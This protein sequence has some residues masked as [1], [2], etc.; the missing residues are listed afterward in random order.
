MSQMDHFKHS[1]V[2]LYMELGD[3]PS[4]VTNLLQRFLKDD[5][6]IVGWG[7]G[8]KGELGTTYRCNLITPLIIG[9]RDKAVRIGCASTTSVW[10]GARGTVLTMG[11]GRWGELGV[12]N[13]KTCPLVTAT[14]NGLPIAIVQ[15][16]LPTFARED[17][18]IDV[19]G[20]FAY[21]AALSVKGELFLWGANN[22]AQ[23]SPIM[24]NKCCPTAQRRS[25]LSEKIIQVACSNFTVLAL[26]ASG[27][28]Y[29]WGHTFLLGD[30][31]EVLE[32]APEDSVFTL[33]FGLVDRTVVSEPVKVKALE[34][35]SIKLLRMGPWHAVAVSKDGQ[36]Y[37]WGLGRNGSLGHGTESDIRTPTKVTTLDSV[38]T[39]AACGSFHTCFVS[40]EGSVFACGDNQGG[41]CGVFGEM[42]LTTCYP[43]YVPSYH[44]VI[45]ATCGRHHTLLLLETG[46]VIAYGTGLGL[47]IGTGYSMRMVRGV[48]ILDNYT[49]L[50]LSGGSC[51]NFSLAIPKTLS[52]VVLGI[53]HGDVS[54]ALRVIDLKD[55]LLTAGLGQ[56]FSIL[57][58]RRGSCYSMGLGGWGQ[59]GVDVRGVKDFTSD[60]V[61]VVRNAMRLSYFFRTTITQVSAGICFAAAINEGQ[62]VFTWGSNTYGQC[63]LGVN[64]KEYRIISEPREITWLADKLI[65]QVAC[66]CFFGMA[67]SITG[68]VYT[69]GAIECCGNGLQP[70][71]TDVPA[72]LIMNSLGNESHASVL[73]PV[74][75]SGLSSIVSVAAGAWHAVALNAIGEVFV[76]GIGSRGRLGLGNVEDR[77]VPGK[78]AIRAPFTHVGCGPFSTFAITDDGRLYV[79]GANERNQLSAEGNCVTVPTHV[80]DEVKEAVM[81]RH[82]TLVLTRDGEF[83][84]SG[85]MEDENGRYVSPSFYDTDA[86]PPL[87]SKDMEEP[88]SRAIRI[89]GGV[90]HAMVLFE[91][92][93]I[94]SDTITGLYY[95]LREQPKH[96]ITNLF[97]H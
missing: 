4:S 87:I 22:Y 70:L 10:L 53:P 75:V 64:P 46:D 44:K 93:V 73:L 90:D 80:L 28:V 11:S 45:S 77:Y 13:P 79:W 5:G 50:W 2:D 12:P 66:G 39:E 52:L 47:G 97:Q 36:V 84:F 83:L 54:P 25:I 29:G 58:T 38:V 37:T 14:E 95:A 81:G 63:G 88:G 78:I 26:T 67:L 32:Q 33:R 56:G 86:L 40:A 61:P 51:H 48:H 1:L 6:V 92:N 71:P 17:M 74:R 82:Y 31:D 72:N 85:E 49:T 24:E 91:K 89:F 20:G 30:E 96:I 18:L 16:E 34:D 8:G 68:E 35:K 23:C 76:W 15:I 94:S 9:G 69:W 41:Q 21:I 59:L 7:S 60:Q 43:M 62:R 19:Q 3:V 55:G 27:S 57:V 42:K 65:I